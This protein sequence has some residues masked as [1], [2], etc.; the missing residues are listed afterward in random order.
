MRTHRTSPKHFKYRKDVECAFKSLELD[1]G[2]FEAE[3]FSICRLLNARAKKG[4][5]VSDAAIKS[6]IIRMCKTVRKRIPNRQ[7]K[8]L[9]PLPDKKGKSDDDRRRKR[10]AVF[11]DNAESPL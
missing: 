3:Y 5:K 10:K 2:E 11:S 4:F 6:E 8:G 7:Q 1:L 9:I